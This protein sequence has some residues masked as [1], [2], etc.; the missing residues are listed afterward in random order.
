[1]GSLGWSSA[2]AD[3]VLITSNTLAYWNGAYKGA[4]TTADPYTSNLT[5]VGTI[6]KGTWQGTKI[7]VGYGG[8]GNTSVTANRIIYSES[9][10]KLSSAA[11]IYASSSSL[12]INSTT[13]PAN[14]GNFQVKGTSTMQT[15][16]PESTNTYN[17][18]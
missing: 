15:I 4:G 6:S 5:I 14:S 1:V 9:T 7:G 12:A 13:A 8:T 11:S 18:G 2:T 17:L 10:S 16:L 3:N